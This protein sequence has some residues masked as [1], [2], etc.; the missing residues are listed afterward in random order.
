MVHYLIHTFKQHKQLL[1]ILNNKF[2]NQ[3]SYTK[4]TN[5]IFNSMSKTRRY[6]GKLKKILVLKN[7]RFLNFKKNYLFKIVQYQKT[8]I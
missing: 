7:L 8:N 2:M 1:H 6:Y 4:R 3:K 5:K